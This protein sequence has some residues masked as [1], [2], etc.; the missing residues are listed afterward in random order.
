MARGTVMFV[1]LEGAKKVGGT[2]GNPKKGVDVEDA[3]NEGPL[4]GIWVVKK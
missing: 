4:N 3:L 1:G 2:R